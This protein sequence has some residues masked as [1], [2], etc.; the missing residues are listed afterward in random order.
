MAQPRNVLIHEGFR[1]SFAA[2]LPA[3]KSRAARLIE[4]FSPKLGRR[5]TLHDP[6]DFSQWVRLE[7]DADV[8]GYCERPA[9]SAPSLCCLIDF[10]SNAPRVLAWS[11]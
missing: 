2:P 3:T 1:H 10:W 11:S 4:A 6:M 7:A 9:R 5:V 8:L